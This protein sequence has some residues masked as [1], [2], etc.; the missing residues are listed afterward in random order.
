MNKKKKWIFF[1][2]VVVYDSPLPMSINVKEDGISCLFDDP[3][4]IQYF[5]SAGIFKPKCE[6]P[7]FINWPFGENDKH[8]ELS[9][10]L[11]KIWLGIRAR[12]VNLKHENPIRVVPNGIVYA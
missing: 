1:E 8:Q 7:R 12:L 2:N 3:R 9:S 6:Q 5:R 10:D 4:D 11:E